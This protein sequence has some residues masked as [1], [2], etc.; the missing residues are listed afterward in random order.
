MQ[1]PVLQMLTGVSISSSY[2]SLLKLDGNTD[3]TAAGNGSNAIQVKTGD[4]EAT[5]LFLNTDRLGIGGQP[6]EVFDVTGNAKISGSILSSDK[7]TITNA[8]GEF[9]AFAT[10]GNILKL[11]A[12][13][14][15]A[16]LQINTTG[17]ISATGIKS[18]LPFYDDD[19]STLS[20]FVGSGQDLAFG[21]ANDLCIRGVDSIKFTADNGN[22]DAMTI[23]T[24]GA[25]GIGTENPTNQGSALHIYQNHASNNTFLTV[26]SDGASASAFIDIDTATDR[27][28]FIRFK[29]AG[30]DKASIF[31]DASADSLVLTDG[32]NT[33]TVF[34]NSNKV[35]IGTS[36]PSHKLSVSGAITIDGQNTV[37][38]TS[39]MVLSQES[40]AKSQMRLYGADSSTRGELEI[41]QSFNDGNGTL[42]T[43]HL[44]SSGKVGI[45][46][47]STTIDA[48]LH[49]VG[50]SDS[51]AAFKIGANDT[52]GFS[53]FERST[54]G[55]LRITKEA[56]GTHVDVINIKRADGDVQFFKNVE[57]QDIAKVESLQFYQNSVS[58]G[59][60]V[61][62]SRATTN[63]LAFYTNNT[64]RMRITDTGNILPGTDDAQDIGSSSLRFDDIHATNGTI[65]TSDE[66]LKDNIADSSLGLDFVNALRPVKYKWKDYS[67]DIEK[68]KAVEAK[69]AVYETVVVQEAVEA[70]EAVMGTRQKT[71]SKEVEKTKTEIV[72]E[73]GKYVQKEVSYTETVEEPQYEEVNLYD[74]DGNKIQRLVSEAIEAVKSVEYQEA[75]Y[76]TEDDE[77]PEGKEVGD[78]KTEEIQ[79]VEAVE[80][81]D[82]VY[83]DVLY[84]I[85]VM[86]EY[87]VEPAIEAV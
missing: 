61:A 71:V 18:F 13:G 14:S 83:E 37:H 87:E 19:G 66:R 24:S 12:N 53:F 2:T 86:E 3:S 62:I 56:S 26:E 78:I 51:V 10:S 50:N 58:P 48:K 65:Q 42:T 8:S 74:E 5:P 32:S 30:T 77:L 28:G 4:N 79:A 43:L 23:N 34:I 44:D 47:S 35:G 85:P 52:H 40:S 11:G 38:D 25:I 6:T 63:T 41:K 76:Y 81:K 73:D 21:D 20:G 69:E 68:E 54:D 72:E 80:A 57:I 22:A 45:G 7:G 15:D 46:T 17:H 59:A 70:K 49:V 55:D 84:K 16:H 64:E 39:A 33:N 29:E 31:N 67:Y 27:D 75:T 60:D 9:S 82:A 1:Q 36:S